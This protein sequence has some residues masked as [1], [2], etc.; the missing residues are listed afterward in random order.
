MVERSNDGIH[1]SSIGT[2]A[3]LGSSTSKHSYQLNDVSALQAGSS[4]LYYRLQTVNKDGS[5]SSSNVLTV[6]LQNGLFMFTLSPNPV[7]NQLTVS[8]AVDNATHAVLRITDADGKPLYQQ[9]YSSLSQSS[10]Q[11]NINVERLTRGVYFIQLITDKE[12]KTLRFVK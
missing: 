8:F 6:R 9:A 1:F 4:I 3:A 11:Q 7:R 12:T 5:Y 2:L 10:V